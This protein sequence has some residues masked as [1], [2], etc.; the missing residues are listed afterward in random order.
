MG[1]GRNRRRVDRAQE[2]AAA[3]HGARAAGR[4]L[5]ALGLLGL[6]GLGGWQAWRYLTTGGLLR[7]REIRIAGA[8]AAGTA[9]LLE[10]SPVKR[11]DNLLLAD[12]DAMS[13]ALLRHPWVAAVE[14]RRRWPPAL[15]VSVRERRAVAMVDLGGLYLVDRDG[16]PFKRAAPGDGLDLP[17]VTGFTRDDYV[18]RRADVD[19]LLRGALGLAGDW[20]RAG[21][22]RALPL[23]EIHLDGAEGVTLYAGEEGLQIRLGAGPAGPKLERLAA[24]LQALRA[25]GK[26]AEV[27]LLDDRAHPDWVTVRPRAVAGTG[28]RGP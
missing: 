21:L 19:P 2:A 24:V 10:L 14:I 27:V 15:E 1:R 4:A 12:V 22:E 6:L 23:S 17:L 16:L 28:S 26:R 5:V 18:Q 13:R 9:E 25:E 8:R 11:G 3:G 20:A 7:I